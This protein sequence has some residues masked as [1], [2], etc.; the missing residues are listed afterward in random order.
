MVREKYTQIALQDKGTNDSYCCGSGCCTTE[1]YNIMT[2]DYTN[3]KDIMQTQISDWNT[4]FLR[5]LH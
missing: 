1:V 5:S 3:L 2:D 4:D